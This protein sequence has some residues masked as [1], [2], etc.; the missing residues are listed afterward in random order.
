MTHSSATP[1]I[2]RAR[3]ADAEALAAVGSATFAE[4]FGH[5]YPPADLAAF[6]AEAHVPARW[7]ADLADPTGAAWLVE[8]DGQAVGYA[9]AGRCALPHTDVTARCG[10]LKAFYLLKPWQ[11][12]GLGGRL[13]A[14]ALAWLEAA[15]DDLWI[16]VWSENL[17]AQQFYA[18]RGFSKV[19]E[20]GFPV[21]EIVDQEFILKRTAAG[22]ANN[23]PP[24]S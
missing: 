4:T 9:R 11:G 13:F 20:Y 21:G 16:G 19:G 3:T 23:P 12:G 17:G 14:E 6:L 15:Y 24:T 8:V 2:R 7:A 10:E 1:A 18:R 5:L 22:S